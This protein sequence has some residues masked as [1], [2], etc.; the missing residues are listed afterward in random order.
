MES[1]KGASGAN[2]NDDTNTRRFVANATRISRAELERRIS[3]RKRRVDSNDK[4]SAPVRLPIPPIPP[5]SSN[6]KASARARPPIPPIPPRSVRDFASAAPL[7]MNALEEESPTLM[8]DSS[9]IS[10]PSMDISPP[11]LESA[12]N[13][14]NSTLIQSSATA[15][16]H[17]PA[18]PKV[19]TTRPH[20]VAKEAP[21]R[22]TRNMRTYPYPP[23]P[24]MSPE[25]V[26]SGEKKQ[27]TAQPERRTADS[28]SEPLSAAENAPRLPT[29]AP[30]T[31][32]RARAVPPPVPPTFKRR[33][34]VDAL[35]ARL[36]NAA[37]FPA[38]PVIVQASN[39]PSVQSSVKPTVPAPA[40]ATE[41]VDALRAR[42]QKN[43]ARP[44]VQ[45][46]PR[47]GVQAL[48]DRLAATAAASK[49]AYPREQFPVEARPHVAATLIG[50]PAIGAARS[51]AWRWTALSTSGAALFMLLLAGHFWV[52]SPP[53]TPTNAPAP[54]A[55]TNRQ[56]VAVGVPVDAPR[57]S[58]VSAA[59]AAPAAIPVAPETHQALPPSTKRAIQ[60]VH[61]NNGSVPER[62]IVSS[63]PHLSAVSASVTSKNRALPI[64]SR[65]RSQ[66]FV[67]RENT[68][69][70]GPGLRA[71]PRED[72]PLNES[73]G[74]RKI[75][76]VSLQETLTPVGFWN[77]RP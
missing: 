25:H 65:T 20:V 53:V 73:E 38:T 77:N 47:T 18:P 19:P 44:A 50:Q 72:K 59:T 75:L 49:S 26:T 67:D 45:S 27:L 56:S 33:V 23:I 64:H 32:T 68:P 24:Q 4:A 31:A 69:R 52:V 1:R 40:K 10:S 15:K 51:R 48:R 8:W 21:R 42:L 3:V 7:L 70:M 60:G 41:T 54:V 22:V 55:G 6:D 66:V 17:I 39:I 5:R 16:A 9:H 61:I 29:R 63:S 35:R 71:S 57:S 62:T 46:A 12:A 2:R 14:G 30:S 34:T 43:A 11:I 37:R 28:K 74:V 58:A 76:Q 13:V 36:K